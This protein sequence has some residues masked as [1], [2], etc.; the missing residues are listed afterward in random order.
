M[1]KKRSYRDACRL[2][3]A[4]DTV[5]ERWALLVIRELLLGPKRFT[6]LRTGLPHA[7]STIL[8]ER[9]R[10]LEQSGVVRRRKLPPPFAASVYELTAWG[11]ELEPILTGLGAWGARA[12]TPPAA[13]AI[14]VDSI[15]LALR[16]LFDPE[17]AGEER[18]SCALLL[19]GEPF[20]VRV[21]GGEI[22][23]SRETSDDVDASLTADPGTL[24][25]LLTGQLPL[26]EAI[27]AGAIEVG[28][29]RSALRRFLRLFPMPEPLE[30]AVA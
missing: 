18:T 21:A 26:E 16:S 11:R 6:D 20:V 19:D 4:L 12:P 2:A 22:E 5:G 10:D 23:L 15:V 25:A 9:L 17:A 27:A 28:G 7:S 24:A 29:S 13:Q 30:L 14:G 8:A 1:S 3:H